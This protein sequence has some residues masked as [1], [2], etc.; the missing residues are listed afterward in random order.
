MIILDTNVISA[1]MR[2]RQDPVIAQWLNDFPI[3]SLWLTAI[4][5]FEI[6]LGI[7]VLAAGKK[8][9]QL[10]QD[11][12]RALFDDFEGRVLALDEA[13]AQAAGVLDG[14]RRRDGRPIEMRDTLIAGIAI[15]QKAALATGN[16]RHFQDLDIRLFNPWDDVR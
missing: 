15:A 11:F 16:I 14:Q 4:T 8:R 7:E 3:E 6:R 10:E 12:E 13:A 5:V 9:R 2:T 1:A